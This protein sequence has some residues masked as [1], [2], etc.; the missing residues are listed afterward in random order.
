MSDMFTDLQELQSVLSDPQKG[1]SV[2]LHHSYVDLEF[3]LPDG[4]EIAITYVR[5]ISIT[6]VSG[7]VAAFLIEQNNGSLLVIP[8]IYRFM[9]FSVKEVIP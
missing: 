6:D 7:A 3:L 5:R 2:T 9:T 1:K 8:P 4:K